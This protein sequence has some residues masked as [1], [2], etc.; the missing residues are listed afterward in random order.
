MLHHLERRLVVCVAVVIWR[1]DPHIVLPLAV[2]VSMPG[3]EVC[4]DMAQKK[5]T[6][7]A[8]ASQALYSTHAWQP[9]RIAEIWEGTH[10]M[11]TAAFLARSSCR[12]PITMSAVSNLQVQLWSLMALLLHVPDFSMP[13]RPSAV[14]T[15]APPQAITLHTAAQAHDQRQTLRLIGQPLPARITMV[16]HTQLQY[17]SHLAPCR[18]AT[19]GP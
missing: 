1:G 11:R 2:H 18:E 4:I 9:R 12:R 15:G 6:E 5:A 19:P 16:P 17:V 10:P 7:V 3:H 14:S 13:R 8:I